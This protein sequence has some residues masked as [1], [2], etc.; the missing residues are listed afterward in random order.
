MGWHACLFLPNAC[1]GLPWWSGAKPS[2][3]QLRGLGFNPWSRNYILHAATKTQCRQI[4]T[5]MYTCVCA[6]V[7]HTRGWPRAWEIVEQGQQKAPC[8]PLWGRG[9]PGLMAEPPPHPASFL[10]VTQEE[11]GGEEAAGGRQTPGP[12]G[13]G[14]S[15]GRR[16]HTGTNSPPAALASPALPAGYLQTAGAWRRFPEIKKIVQSDIVLGGWPGNQEQRPRVTGSGRSSSG[17]PRC[18]RGHRKWLASCSRYPSAPPGCTSA[19]PAWILG[20]LSLPTFLD[21]HPP[22]SGQIPPPSLW[23]SEMLV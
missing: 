21:W 1:L 22:N 2:C 13:G 17:H 4:K 3:S 14:S 6:H 7:S 18:L 23:N 19:C 8:Q 9:P 12:G 16:R 5:H 10:R 15:A 20:S 11:R